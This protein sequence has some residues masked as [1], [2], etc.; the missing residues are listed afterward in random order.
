MIRWVTWSEFSHVDFVMPDGRLLGARGDGVRVRNPYGVYQFIRAEVDAP[1]SVL[2]RAISQIGKP[3]DYTAIVGFLFRRNWQLR[4]AWDCAEL[5]AWAFS[6][7]GHAILST[8]DYHR[9]T[10]RDILLSTAVRRTV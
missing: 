6:A 4:E 3:Y 7:E 2:E 9:I 10:P 5:V 1:D 8:S